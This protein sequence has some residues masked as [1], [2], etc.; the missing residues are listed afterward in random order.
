MKPA[1]IPKWYEAKSQERPIR[2]SH[3][4][5]MNVELEGDTT[6]IRQILTDKF[7]KIDSRF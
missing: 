2:G 6:H 1:Y 3:N 5:W 4:K 7:D